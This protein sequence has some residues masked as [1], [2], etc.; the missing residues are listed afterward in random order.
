MLCDKDI[1]YYEDFEARIRIYIFGENMHKEVYKDI[2]KESSDD[3]PLLLS[4]VPS[5]VHM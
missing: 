1:D 3:W 2:T 4:Y 5:L